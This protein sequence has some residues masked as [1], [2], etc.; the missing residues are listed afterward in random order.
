M[1]FKQKN[2]SVQEQLDLLK[3]EN[4]RLKICVNSLQKLLSNNICQFFELSLSIKQT[5][6]RFCYE[7]V[8]DCYY[9]LVYFYGCS[10]PVEDAEDYMECYM[11][12]FGKEYSDYVTEYDVIYE[13]SISDDEA[14][15]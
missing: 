11:D 10:D 2:A 14:N 6:K 3:Q 4:N 7:N 12:I 9:D 15:F 1:N 5:K 13:E 8:R